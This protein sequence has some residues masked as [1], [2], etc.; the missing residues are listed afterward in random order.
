[1]S[2]LLGL[3][4]LAGGTVGTGLLAA[5]VSSTRA[6]DLVGKVEAITGKA[7]ASGADGIVRPMSLGAEIFALDTVLTEDVSTLGIRFVDDA[8]FDL[9]PNAEV[10]IDEHIYS[11]GSETFVASVLHG[12]FRFV[13]GGI[14]KA[15]NNR[16]EIHLP[17]AVIGVRGTHVAGEVAGDEGAKQAAVTLLESE[18]GEPSALVVTNEAGTTVMHEPGTGT[19]IAGSGE[20]PSQARQWAQSRRDAFVARHG[21][22]GRLQESARRRRES[23]RQRMAGMSAQERTQFRQDIRQRREA[24]RASLQDPARHDELRQRYRQKR[25]DR[26]QRRNDRTPDKLRQLREQ[27]QQKLQQFRENRQNRREQNSE[28]RNNGAQSLKEQMRQRREERQRKRE[29]RR[30]L[31]EQRN[32]Q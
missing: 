24:L 29:E 10:T 17:V 27:R 8:V 11:P 14:S 5:N 19:D 9:G 20:R 21:I 15:R 7:H 3:R 22:G 16:T 12:G 2:S 23:L 26:Q 6:A 25:Q 28:Q 4:L 31:R 30:R 13:S 1:L 32:S 18:D